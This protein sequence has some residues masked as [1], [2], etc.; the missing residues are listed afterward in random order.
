MTGKT[1]IGQIGHWAVTSAKHSQ[2]GAQ[3][4]VGVGLTKGQGR[5]TVVT[6]E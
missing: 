4:R 1:K 3:D 5:P 2:E 6:F